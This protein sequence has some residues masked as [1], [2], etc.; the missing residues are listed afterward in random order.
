MGRGTPGYAPIEQ[1]Q[2]REGVD[3]PVTMDVYALG[4]TMHQALTGI[5]PTLSTSPFVFKPVREANPKISEAMAKI[6][7]K[8]IKVVPEER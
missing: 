8:A 3:F 6:V 1:A 7:T 2:Y 5:D 4:A